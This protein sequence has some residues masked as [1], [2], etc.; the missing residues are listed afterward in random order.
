MFDAL[1]GSWQGV[2]R[3]YLEGADGP[4]QASDSTLTAVFTV[5]K[6]LEIRYTWSYEGQPQEGLLLLGADGRT[7][8]W[9]DSWHQ[10]KDV[11]FCQGDP[12]DV[13]GTYAVAGHP[14]WGWRIQVATPADT[15]ELTMYNLS[16]EG[17]QFLAVRA[18]YQ[19]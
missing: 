18:A 19:R 6:F 3:L 12:L 2:S 11:M 7:A 4:E 8:S 5:R 9:V 10:S 13:R 16:P 15:L 1:A 14:R 17:E